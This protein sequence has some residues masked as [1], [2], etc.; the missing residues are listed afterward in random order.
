MAEVYNFEY[1]KLTKELKVLEDEFNKQLYCCEKGNYGNW[2]D[3]L[4]LLRIQYRVLE[5]E[6]RL[7]QIK[8]D[9]Q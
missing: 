6:S 2:I 5:V 4:N 8:N 3:Y 9:T 1:F 7:A